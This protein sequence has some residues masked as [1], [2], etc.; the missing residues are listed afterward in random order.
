MTLWSGNIIMAA[1]KPVF[2]SIDSS[3]WLLILLSASGNINYEEFLVKDDVT[4]SDRWQRVLRCK[5]CFG[6]IGFV[7]Q[8]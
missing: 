2:K 4:H 3:V 7:T 8:Y 6:G 1:L 5:L